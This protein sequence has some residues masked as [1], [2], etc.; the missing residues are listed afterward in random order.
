MHTVYAYANTTNRYA[1]GWRH[2]DEDKFVATVRL[3]QPHM[4]KRGMGYDEGDT[5][6]QYVRVPRNVSTVELRR[7]LRDT[8]GGSNCK[9]EHD[10]CGCA[11][12][13][14]ST[15]VVAPRRLLVRTQVSYNY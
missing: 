7:A 14:V 13:R 12:H 8:L 4:I 15:K 3:T 5:Y 11:T 6:T 1:A 9:H 10:C 2:L